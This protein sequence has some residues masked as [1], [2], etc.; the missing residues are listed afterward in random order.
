MTD[1]DNKPANGDDKL[2]AQIFIALTIMIILIIA[3]L[4]ISFDFAPTSIEVFWGMTAF[5]GL[6][7]LNY[8]VFTGLK[9]LGSDNLGSDNEKS[10]S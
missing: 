6:S 3:G 4:I 10:S 1:A 9:K 8:F 2:M 5:L 7:A